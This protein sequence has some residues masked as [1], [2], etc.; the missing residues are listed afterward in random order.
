MS[1][2]QANYRQKSETPIQM[3]SSVT[4]TLFTLALG[5]E[6]HTAHPRFFGGLQHS[7]LPAECLEDEAEQPLPA[8]RRGTRGGWQLGPDPP[9]Q[10]PEPRCVSV[11][12]RSR[13][14]VLGR[15]LLPAA[16]LRARSQRLL[17]AEDE[18][19]GLF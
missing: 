17:G 19:C 14:L 13:E 7:F 12:Q 10:I 2:I 11:V 1:C 6:H 5:L 9:A 15:G 3:K 8:C 16:L 18:A 4:E